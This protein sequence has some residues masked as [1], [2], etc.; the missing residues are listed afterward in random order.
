[1]WFVWREFRE[2]KLERYKEAEIDEEIRNLL[3]LINSVE[4]F[5]TLSSCSGRIA[6]MD[7]P[8]FGEK[9]ESVFLGK[10]HSVPNY[11]DVYEAV[12]R[13]K[14]TTWLMM[15][16]PIVHVACKD[17]RSAEE[18]LRVAKLSGFRRSGIISPKKFVVEIAAPE[19]VEAVVAVGGKIADEEFLRINYEIAVE[20]LI[21][22]RRRMEKF[23]EYFRE[24][25]R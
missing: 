25:F 9:V 14:R 12:R 5:V 2:E 23:E 19:R 21:K 17:F 11:N 18:I 4:K 22:S 6:V 16:P 1:M 7:M 8:K 20:K 24:A 15:H 10:W 3:D 13:G